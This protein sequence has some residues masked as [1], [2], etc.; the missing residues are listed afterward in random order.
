[1][2]GCVNMCTYACTYIYNLC[3]FMYRHIFSAVDST[4]FGAI[5][6]KVTRGGNEVPKKWRVITCIVITSPI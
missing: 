4:P 1:M 3:T 5:N 2:Y 6:T